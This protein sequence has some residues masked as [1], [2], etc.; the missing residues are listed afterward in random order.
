MNKQV[1]EITTEYIPLGQFL[2][3]AGIIDTGG[4]AKM[5]LAETHIEVNGETENRRGKKLYNGDTVY[6]D[7]FGTYEVS[8]QTDE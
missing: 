8:R 5:I 1:V 3:L 7:G 6:V 2:K 4:Q